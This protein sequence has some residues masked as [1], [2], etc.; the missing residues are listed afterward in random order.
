[1]ASPDNADMIAAQSSEKKE[2][3]RKSIPAQQ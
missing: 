1:M 2:F 3:I